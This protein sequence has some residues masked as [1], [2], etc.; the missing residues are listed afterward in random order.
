MSYQ[1]KYLPGS[2][3]RQKDADPFS[4]CCELRPDE[5]HIRVTAD[6]RRSAHPHLADQHACFSQ[7]RLALINDL[8][9][10]RQSV[11]ST[12]QTE[13]WFAPELL[14]QRSHVGVIH[15]RR[16]AEDEDDADRGS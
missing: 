5:R 10:Q 16:V 7:S 15:I 2:L 12:G 13:G 8:S 3:A 14:R 11:F 4:A 6:Q 9:G 1:V